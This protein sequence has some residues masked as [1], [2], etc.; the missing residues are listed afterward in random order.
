MLNNYQKVFLPVRL[1]RFSDKAPPHSQTRASAFL[2]AFRMPAT[3]STVKTTCRT[4]GC[5]IHTMP[6]RGCP[7]KEGRVWSFQRS[8]QTPGR[9]CRGRSLC[10]EGK[11]HKQFGNE[12]CEILRFRR[13]QKPSV[14][15]GDDRH[16]C[17]PV[18]ELIAVT[19]IAALSGDGIVI[20]MHMP[21]ILPLFLEV[22][23]SLTGHTPSCQR[24]EAQPHLLL[25]GLYPDLRRSSSGRSSALPTHSSE[26]RDT[27]GR[28]SPGQ[29]AH[30]TQAG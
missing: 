4:P 2:S 16:Q 14:H 11:S 6:S 9:C 20:L 5:L 24:P 17:T 7:S 1:D 19:D 3:S 12:R 27:A 30:R 15:Q 18:I 23:C 13:S 22:F 26:R 25:K 21:V 29:R 8:T 10:Y 28:P